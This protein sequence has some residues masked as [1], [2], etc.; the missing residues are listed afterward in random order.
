M[1][2][3]GADTGISRNQSAGIRTS[4]G[5]KLAS[6]L[7]LP[8]KQK[9]GVGLVWTACLLSLLHLAVPYGSGQPDLSPRLLLTITVPSLLQVFWPGVTTS[10]KE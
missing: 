9:V 6:S 1:L 7:T 2:D 5:G 3:P 8:L 4:K 10:R